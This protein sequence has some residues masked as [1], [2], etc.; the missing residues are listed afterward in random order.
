M[1]EWIKDIESILWYKYV[2]LLQ[3]EKMYDAI[4]CT[5]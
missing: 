5:K 4:E 2:F 3:D 1:N